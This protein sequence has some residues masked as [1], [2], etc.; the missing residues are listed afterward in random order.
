M[1]L[2]Q[3]AGTVE[4]YRGTGQPGT[5]LYQGSGAGEAKHEEVGRK[6]GYAGRKRGKVSRK[7]IIRKQQ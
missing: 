4:V 3:S 7:H 5:R 6:H 2:H 1:L